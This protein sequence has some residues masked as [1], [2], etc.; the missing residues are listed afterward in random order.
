MQKYF[1]SI[2]VFFLF[3]T[4]V[5]FSQEKANTI[6]INKQVEVI[7]Y[8]YE[9][10]FIELISSLHYSLCYPVLTYGTI[11]ESQQ[12]F[13]KG[14]NIRP[15]FDVGF[16]QG[17]K[18][19]SWALTAGISYQQYTELFSY[20][21]YKTRDVTIQNQDGSMQTITV[22]D[23]DPITY[24]RNNRLGY[25]KI[26]VGVGFYPSYF[27]NKFG[28]NLQFNYHYL[29]SS[30]YVSKYSIIQ[31]ASIVVLEDFN[32]SFLSLSGSLLVHT[33]IFK[34]LSVTFEPYFDW[35][36]NNLIDKK[37][38]T[39]GVNTIGLRAGLTHFY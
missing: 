29:L 16:T 20:N 1:T 26:P 37:D 11:S 32:P 27:K 28:I 7:E 39:F 18:A 10:V 19:G 36:I 5:S 6:V 30:D 25:L 33:K 12:F 23:G 4:A 24:S 8:D 9:Y 15:G 35:G 38:L 34:N 14:R 13:E 3:N 2:L 21:E 17:V 31:P 22:T